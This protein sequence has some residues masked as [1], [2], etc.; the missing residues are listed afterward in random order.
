MIALIATQ[1]SSNFIV[2]NW[3]VAEQL[4]QRLFA[5]RKLP[6]GQSTITWSFAVEILAH[7]DAQDPAGTHFTA[8]TIPLPYNP[9]LTQKR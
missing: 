2:P 6:R 8:K 7:V 5:L 1:K 9:W 3:T 4:F